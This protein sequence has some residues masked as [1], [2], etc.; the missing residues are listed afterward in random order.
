MAEVRYIVKD[1][2]ASIRFYQD[3]LGFTLLQQFGPAMAIIARRDLRLWLAGP[4]ASAAKPMPDGTQPISGGWNRIVIPVERIEDVVAT[5]KSQGVHFRND[6]LTGPGGKQVLC[7]DPSG[8]PLE[9]F[10]AAK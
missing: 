6:V 9:L 2:D 3:N 4:M 1:V 10:E 8:N 5:M 7:E